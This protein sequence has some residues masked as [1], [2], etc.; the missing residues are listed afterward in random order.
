MKRRL[1]LVFASNARATTAEESQRDSGSKP[2]VARH[3]LPWVNIGRNFLNPNG[4]VAALR[5]TQPQPRWGWLNLLRLT[6]G[7]SCLA[8]LGWMT[9]SRWDCP[10]IPVE[11]WVK[12]MA[13]ARAPSPDCTRLKKFICRG[14]LN[15]QTAGRRPARRREAR[16]KTP[17]RYRRN[18]LCRVS[19]SAA[20]RSLASHPRRC[21]RG[22]E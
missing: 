19:Q 16:G 15:S 22:W 12:T 4:V 1:H 3:E 8:T 9:Q 11:F 6:Q 17:G 5:Q 20:R 7:S 13:E 10:P 18:S 14:K 21:T 2:K